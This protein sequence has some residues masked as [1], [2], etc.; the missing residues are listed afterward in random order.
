M[1]TN[2]MDSLSRSFVVVNLGAGGDADYNLPLPFLKTITLIEA[3]GGSQPIGTSNRYYKKYTVHN[4]IAGNK[5]PRRFTRRK[6]WACSSIY[7]PRQ[8]LISQYGLEYYYE[9]ESNEDVVPI[10]LS[11]ILK[12]YG[13][14]SIDYLKTDLEGVDFEVI[15]SCEY[16][17]DQVLAIKCELRFQPFYHGEPF[18]HEVVSYLH[19]FD[20]ELIGL[21][22]AY[23]KPFTAHVKD[24]RDGRVAFVDCLFLKKIDAVRRMSKEIVELAA[25]KQIIIA[26]MS[27]KKCY[28]EWLLDQYRDII[29]EKLQDEIRSLVIPHPISRYFAEVVKRF[30]F[31]TIKILRRLS[32]IILNHKGAKGFDDT[33]VAPGE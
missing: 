22:P 3:D 23:W 20:F 2:L 25:V 8:E 16:I 28:G 11:E 15:K 30:G 9:A 27:G 14:N 31:L 17:I 21:K 13:L 33:Y 26:A 12:N 7:E 32:K 1:E 19:Q 24:H 10:T 5:I 4:I 6:Y 18:F 29:P